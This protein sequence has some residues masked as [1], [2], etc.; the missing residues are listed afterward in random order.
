M[1]FKNVVYYP[2]GS[3]ILTTG[4]DRRICYWETFDGQ[5]LRSLESNDEEQGEVSS[6]DITQ[7]GKYFLS[8]GSDGLLK[9][10]DYDLGETVVETFAHS[11]GIAS[12]ALS[13]DLNSVVSV[14]NEGAIGIWQFKKPS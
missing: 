12:L 11:Q 1:V 14:G 6:M 7:D 5:L 2:D 9:L 8:G 10:W 4:T 3:Q 13:P